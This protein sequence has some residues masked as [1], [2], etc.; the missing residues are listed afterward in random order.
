MTALIGRAAASFV[1]AAW[2]PVRLSTA[3]APCDVFPGAPVAVTISVLKNVKDGTS[4][5]TRRGAR[6]ESGALVSVAEAGSILLPFPSSLP[7]Q[8]C[9]AGVPPAGGQCE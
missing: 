2:N 6:G 7:M 3:S 8:W 1:T 4:A 9:G 5:G